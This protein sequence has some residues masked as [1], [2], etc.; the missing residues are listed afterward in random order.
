MS[1]HQK[2]L[3]KIEI[4][5]V[6]PIFMKCRLF[7]EDIK[8]IFTDTQIQYLYLFVLSKGISWKFTNK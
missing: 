3:Y 6:L 8:L 1:V 2:L 7:I 4:K 5:G